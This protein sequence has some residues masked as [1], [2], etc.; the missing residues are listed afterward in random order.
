MA[1]EGEVVDRDDRA[2]SPTLSEMQ[3]SGRERRLPVVGVDDLGHEGGDRAEPD[4]R[5]NPRER[6]EAA[7]VVR[8]VKSVGAQVGVAGAVVEMR[9]VDRKQIETLC[10]AGKHARGSA[11]QI[12]DIHARP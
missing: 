1:L 7:G 5:A 4:L 6:G 2:R 8:P 9:R 3:I 11:E 12:D 10:L